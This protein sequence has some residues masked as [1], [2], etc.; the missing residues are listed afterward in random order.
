MTVADDHADVAIVGAGPAGLA[1]ASELRR[2]TDASVVVLDREPESGGVPRHSHHQGFGLR[3]LHMSLTG[4]S[5]ARRRT[6]LAQRAGVVLRLSTQV[7][8]WTSDGGL[9]LTS[10]SGRGRLH[11]RAVILATGCRERPRSARMVA[12]DR[13]PGVMTTGTLQQLVH[14]VGESPGRHAI[15]V[16]AEHVSFSALSTL[17]HGGAETVAITT[18]LAHHQTYALLRLG[19]ALRFRTPVLTRTAVTAVHGR[20]RVEAVEL[21]DLSTGK[22]RA[23]ACDTV[24]FTADWVPDHEL[25]ALAGLALDHATRGPRVDGALR[26]ARP[27]LFAAGNVLH[28]AETADVAALAGEHV[29]GAVRD[30]LQGAAWPTAQVPLVC[31]APLR[32]CSPGAVAVAPGPPAAPPRGRY[33]LRA[34]DELLDVRVALIQDGRTLLGHRLARVTAGRSAALPTSWAEA[35]DP[36]GGPVVVRV[37]RARRR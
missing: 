37:L 1:A 13:P 4:P 27:G 24:V 20:R 32:W 26:T 6:E 12:G 35:V 34:R 10:P 18:E 15:V 33:L 5:Y 19:A 21:T 11:A 17:A 29:A 8:G 36:A 28:G 22:A 30:F 7:T 2:V 16:G 9:E 14:L 23:L 31:E 25:A 3:D